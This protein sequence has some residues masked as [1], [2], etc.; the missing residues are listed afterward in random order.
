M[1]GD[2]G[3]GETNVLPYR[4]VTMEF[5]AELMLREGKP[6]E[7]DQGERCTRLGASLPYHTRMVWGASRK[8]MLDP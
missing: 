6:L 2:A 7:S 1:V 5:E 4:A 8:P 3:T